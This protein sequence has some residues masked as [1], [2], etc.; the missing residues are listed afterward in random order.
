[1]LTPISVVCRLYHLS[2]PLSSSSCHPHPSSSGGGG[3]GLAY[4]RSG[5]HG[6]VTVAVAADADVPDEPPP[7]YNDIFPEGYQYNKEDATQP[8]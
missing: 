2:P 4:T 1:L 8:P 7:A 3:G 5:A 6:E